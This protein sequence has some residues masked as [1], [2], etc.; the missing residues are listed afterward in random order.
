M[1][2]LKKDWKD[3]GI[4]SQSI[5]ATQSWTALEHVLSTWTLGK[6]LENSRNYWEAGLRRRN[7]NFKVKRRHITTSIA[8]LELQRESL[9]FPEIF[10]SSLNE[11]LVKLTWCSDRKHRQNNQEVSVS[12]C[13]TLEFHWKMIAVKCLVKW[14]LEWK[15]F[16]R[17]KTENLMQI[18]V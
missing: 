3:W 10:I 18:S 8:I 14:Q 1:K 2:R 13:F 17:N 5:D 7:P 15:C 12:T 16:Q 11:M 4:L 9:E 6:P